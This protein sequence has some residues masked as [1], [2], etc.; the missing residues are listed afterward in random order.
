MAV[1]THL[2]LTQSY[3]DAESSGLD[4][5]VMEVPSVYLASL[6]TSSTPT[7]FTGAVFGGDMSRDQHRLLLRLWNHLRSAGLRGLG[8]VGKCCHGYYG[9]FGVVRCRWCAVYL[10]VTV[11]CRCIVYPCVARCC[12]LCTCVLPGVACCVCVVMC[13]V[14]CICVVRCCVLCSCV[15]SGAVY[16][17]RVHQGGEAVVAQG[18]SGDGVLS[19][20]VLCVVR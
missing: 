14:L 10:C 3:P 2:D 18:L 20:C 16:H 4:L 7:M 17:V 6:P 1:C 15:L 9:A 19:T 8:A 13:C 12:V 5:D 11:R